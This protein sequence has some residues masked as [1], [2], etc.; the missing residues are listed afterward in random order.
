MIKINYI[1]SFHLTATIA[2]LRDLSHV[3]NLSLER[4]LEAISRESDLL[5]ARAFEIIDLRID[6][7]FAPVCADSSDENS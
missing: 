1:G 4:A 7:C 3:C 2:V 5:C 6:Q